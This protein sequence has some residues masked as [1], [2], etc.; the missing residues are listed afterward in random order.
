[1]MVMGQHLTQGTA[2]VSANRTKRHSQASAVT[3]HANNVQ[4][5]ASTHIWSIKL[6]Y[7]SLLH[8]IQ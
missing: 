1:M 6:Y 2:A 8:Y 4:C 7:T 3:S 5:H